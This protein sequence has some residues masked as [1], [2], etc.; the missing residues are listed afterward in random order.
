MES[1]LNDGICVPILLLFLAF[2]TGE[3]GDGNPLQLAKTLVVEEI[4]IGLAVGLLITLVAEWLLTLAQARHWL[5]ETWIQ[6]PI[7]A[8][9]LTC[10][11]SAQCLGGS[12]FIAAYSGGLLF[13]A[14]A[15]QQRN[16][17]LR[18]AESTGDTMVLITWVLFG[19]AVAGQ[20]LSYFN[21]MILVYAILNLTLIRM[22]PV[23]LA[24][25]GLGAS[26]EDKL[27]IGWFG[28]RGL[29][30]IVFAVIVVNADLSNSDS[31]TM[32]VVCTVILSIILHGLTASPWAKGY[33][34][35]SRIA[36]I[37]RIE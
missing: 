29:A 13:G 28:P 23:F 31:I 11:T 27:F 7:I 19:S 5:I 36:Q 26:T 1:G 21:W 8:L 6:I 34:D 12:G 17:F 35:R 20:A 10:F 4:G 14:L 25:T 32:T 15:K 16:E 9:A 3:S 33:G 37:K 30:S 22:L 18:A 24:L 2:A